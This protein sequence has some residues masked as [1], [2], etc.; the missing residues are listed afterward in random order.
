MTTILHLSS[1]ARTEGSVSR[2]LTKRLIDRFPS[3]SVVIERDLADGVPQLTDA[4]I[5]AVYT[6]PEQRTTEQQQ[7]LSVGDE[8]IAEL[9]NADVVVIGTPIYNFGPPAEL[10][11]WFDHVARSGET[12]EANEG[13]FTG[14]LEDRPTYVAFASGGVPVG[15]PVDFLTPWIR[16]ALGLVGISSIEVVAAEGVFSDETAVE[17]AEKQ[18]DSLV[19]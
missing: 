12:F 7:L 9:R 16:A 5:G 6:P 8:F 1:S 13:G 3:D 17:G 14:L 15:S 10:K 18:V 4:H 2:L 11:A 19:L